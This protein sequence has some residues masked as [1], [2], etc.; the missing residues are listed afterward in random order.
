MFY[1]SLSKINF[2]EKYLIHSKIR[3]KNT[4]LKLILKNVIITL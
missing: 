3:I 4:H 1:K 2:T